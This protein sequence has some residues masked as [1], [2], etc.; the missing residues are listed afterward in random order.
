MR[1][2]YFFLLF[3]QKGIPPTDSAIDALPA[4]LKILGT[5]EGN[6]CG[7]S[8]FGK[9]IGGWIVQLEFLKRNAT[10]LLKTFFDNVPKL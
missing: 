1:M 2:K 7:E 3:Y 4:I 9:V 8:I 10:T 6:T 5:N